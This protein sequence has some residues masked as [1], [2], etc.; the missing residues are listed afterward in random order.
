[1]FEY[2]IKYFNSYASKSLVGDEIDLIQSFFVPKKFRK[3]Q[4]FLQEGEIC[5]YTSFI[6]RGAM[7][8]YGVDEKGEEH[9][10]NLFIENWW[11]SDRESLLNQTPS[12]YFIDAWEDTEV[13]RVAKTD[14]TYLID[15]IPLLTEWIRK[16]DANFAIASQNR[17]SAA[18]SLPAQERYYDLEKNYPEFL[19]RFPQQIIASYLGINR[20]TL[21]R[22][23]SRAVKKVN[24]F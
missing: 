21:S 9:I 4:Y 6:V 22:I 15:N 14:L 8:Q 23:R 19:Q 10:I 18:I 24:P 3:R 2:L 13:L 11:A 7:R 1:M 16:L 12:K 5:K 20:E 17:I